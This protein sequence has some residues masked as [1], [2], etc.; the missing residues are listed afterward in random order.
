MRRPAIG[1]F[2]PAAQAELLGARFLRLPSN[3]RLGSK[4]RLS[5]SRPLRFNAAGKRSAST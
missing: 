5:A 2:T 4:L 3:D 1:R